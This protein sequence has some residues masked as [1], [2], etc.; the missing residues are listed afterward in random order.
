MTKP[1]AGKAAKATRAPAG[2]PAKKAGAAKATKPTTRAA[3]PAAAK[4]ARGDAQPGRAK[5]SAAARRA[6]GRS[7]PAPRAARL[8]PFMRA[9]APDAAL[10]ALVGPEPR[11]RTTLLRALWVFI[12][13]NGMQSPGDRDRFLPQGPV[14]ALC[15]DRAERAKT[16]LGALL[17]LHVTPV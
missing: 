15:G 1:G 13:R 3:R 9:V 8:V 5:P 17:D 6:A 2:K 16:A 11:P 10:A 12:K 14:E 4:A 7:A